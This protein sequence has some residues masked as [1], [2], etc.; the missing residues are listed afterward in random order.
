M[1]INSDLS[2]G[3]CSLTIIRIIFAVVG[4]IMGA[5]G[6]VGRLQS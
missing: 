4:A 6:L 1:F 5:L 2:E 3:Y